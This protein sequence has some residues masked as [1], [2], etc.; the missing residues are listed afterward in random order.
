MEGTA[1]WGVQV[2]RVEVGIMM[3]TMIDNNDN[4]DDDDGA[5]GEDGGEE[6]QLISHFSRLCQW[7][8][9]TDGFHNFC[10]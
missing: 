7:E 3:M 1:A 6:Y 8:V 2:E 5:G 9:G 10:F 4:N